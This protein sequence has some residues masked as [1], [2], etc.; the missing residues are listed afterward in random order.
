MSTLEVEQ[1]TQ[2][3]LM[4]QSKIAAR[5]KEL[6]EIFKKAGVDRL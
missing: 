1:V 3:I 2:E 4:V 6:D 5:Q